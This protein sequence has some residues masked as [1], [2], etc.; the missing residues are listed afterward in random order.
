[1][2]S[3]SIII[4]V[5]N[6][7][8]T[9]LKILNLVN[10]KVKELNNFKFEII[11]VDDCSSD[12]TRSILEENKNLFDKIIYNN[13]NYG[14]GFSVKKGIDLAKNEI[15]LI[16]DADLEYLP[17]NYEQLLRP[18]LFNAD[19]VYGSRFRTTEANRVIFFWHFVANSLI[20]FFS[21][22]FSNLNLSDV[23]VGY[24]L[25]KKK[26]FD[27]IK[28]TEKSFGFE[29]EITQKISN[30]KPKLKIYETGISY[31]ARDYS[32]GKKIG[33]K[34][35]FRAVYCIIKFGLLKIKN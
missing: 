24:K 32:E 15:I 12:K 13:K 1:M 17:E 10:Q 8:K 2:L 4:P 33:V 11:V 31:Y 16:Q 23:E 3:L 35:A 14:K 22:C 7:E 34:D 19:A 21:N 28:L 26:I 27:N 20:T 18:F 5:Y 29:I 30:I 25:F 9:I 6:E